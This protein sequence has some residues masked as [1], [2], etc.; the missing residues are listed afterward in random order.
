MIKS[1][2]NSGRTGMNLLVK[3]SRIESLLKRIKVTENGCWEW[4]GYVNSYTGYASVDIRQRPTRIT[5]YL[6]RLFA[7]LANGK[8]DEKA[9]IDHICENKPCCNPRHLYVSDAK[10]NHWVNKKRK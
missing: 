4:Q 1:G 10:K 7:E 3:I 9:V 5:V 8:L 2:Q 6:H